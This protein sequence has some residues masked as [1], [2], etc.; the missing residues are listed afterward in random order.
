MTGFP[1]IRV[2]HEYMMVVGLV[3]VPKSEPYE[4]TLSSSPLALMFTRR[5]G[6]RGLEV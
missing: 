5:L 2:T 3:S 6:S 4:E 1:A